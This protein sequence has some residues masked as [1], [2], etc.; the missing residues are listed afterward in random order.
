VYKWGKILSHILRTVEVN[1]QKLKQLRVDQGFSARQLALKA[2]L[3]PGAVSVAERRGSAS[4][5]TLKRLADVLG[6]RAS[7]LADD[8]GTRAED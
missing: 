4:P 7:E 8:S 2:G 6:V 3:S 5:A 1:V